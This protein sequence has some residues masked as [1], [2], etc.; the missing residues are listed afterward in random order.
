VKCRLF[1][2]T[3]VVSLGLTLGLA[4][5]WLRSQYKSDAIACFGTSRM[6]AIQAYT[7]LLV[8]GGDNR[9]YSTRH[10]KHDSWPV[11]PNV[12]LPRP[13]NPRWWNRLGFNY[14]A[15]ARPTSVS[16]HYPGVTTPAVIQSWYASAPLL[17][18]ILLTAVV[19]LAWVLALHRRRKRGPNDCPVCGY[20]LRATPDR[21]PECGTDNTA[22]TVKAVILSQNGTPV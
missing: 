9:S 19:P 13:T 22:G 12:V 2:L 4:G 5:L 20:D 1:N 6:F 14:I 7:G 8:L 10:W 3:A 17:A 11:S 18:F 15:S 21:C 16:D